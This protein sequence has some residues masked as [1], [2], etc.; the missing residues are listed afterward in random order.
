MMTQTVKL[1]AACLVGASILCAA[2]TASAQEVAEIPFVS[3][4]S[5]SAALGG[6]LRFGQSPYF[7]TDNE[8][9][10]QLDLIPLYLYEGKYL[11]ARGTSGGV[12]VLRKDGF[13]FNLYTRY[14]FQ[15]LD[16]D[17]NI[18]YEGLDKREQ[19][20]DAGVEFGLKQNW[21]EL[22]LD[23]V[24]DTLDRHN[25]QE[26]R[27]SYRYRFETGPWSISPFINWTWQDANLSNYY[28]GVSE[29]EARPDR[30]AYAPGIVSCSSAISVSPAP[31]LKSS[32]AR[33][34]RKSR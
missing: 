20:L 33:W 5:G 18:F 12:H 31:T 3:A 21:G 17:S 32:I 25:G 26:V 13:E 30:P 7:A 23:W 10:R 34:S 9:E 1:V 24:T 22:K 15:K 14:R 29:A 28:F 19:S 6:G 8:D 2:S 16:P 27:F 11:F 4:P